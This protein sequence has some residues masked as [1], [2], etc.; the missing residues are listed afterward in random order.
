MTTAFLICDVWDTHWCKAATCRTGELARRID[1]V[2][3]RLRR[4][5]VFV[6]HAPSDTMPFYAETVPRNRMQAFPRLDPPPERELDEPKAPQTPHLG[7]PDD[8]PCLVRQWSWSRQHPAIDISEDDG[9]SDDEIEI[10]SAVK[11]LGVDRLFYAGV[12]TDICVLDRPF[13]IRQML[14]WGVACALVRDLTEAFW[15]D[16][17]ATIVA[18]IERHLRPTVTSEEML[19]R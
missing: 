8:P 2:L 16:D 4:R 13:G 5:G 1:R 10:Y 18:H 17:T 3:A 19:S 9:V 6:I 14:R 12:H 15:P 7:C 11:G